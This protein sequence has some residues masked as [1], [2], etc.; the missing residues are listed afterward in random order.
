MI[1]DQNIVSLNE[2]FEDGVLHNY[3]KSRID[4]DDPWIGTQ[5]EGYL[6]LS[7]TQMGAFGE[8]LVSKI[9]Q[10]KG[11]EVYPRRNREHDRI[12][13]GYKTEIKFS[14]SMKTD[15]FTF[16]HLACHKDWERLILLGVNPND[17]F[18]INWI[19][20]E[21]FVKN[22]NSNNC[23][24]NHQQGG[25]NSENDDYMFSSDYSKL[26]AAK[27]LQEMSTWMHP[28]SAWMKDDIK[29]IGI[30]LWM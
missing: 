23:V 3:V 19:C 21:D 2:F 18:R 29:K 24:F 26:E 14:L 1:P 10:K 9:M 6:K 13:D 25:K 16:N 7:N 11:S 5:Y 12:I 15:Y 28:C 8:I 27:I 20:K 30:E 17:H 22:I 4:I